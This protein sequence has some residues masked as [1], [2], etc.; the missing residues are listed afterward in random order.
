M[1]NYLIDREI[2]SSLVD[3]LF[4]KKPL[5][6]NNTEEL[7]KLRES[8]I[9]SLDDKIGTAIFSQFTREQNEEYHRLIDREDATEQDFEKFF[10]DSGID[11]EKT[12]TDTMQKFAED[13]IGGQND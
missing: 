5:A 10:N 13:F 9:N 8:T 1:D 6:V 2:L 4:K 7:N 11:L 3:E 12:I